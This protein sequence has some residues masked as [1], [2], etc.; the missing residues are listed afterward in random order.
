[1]VFDVVPESYMGFK[2]VNG[3]END[4]RFLDDKGVIVGLRYKK[5]NTKGF[6]NDAAFKNGF[7]IRTNQEVVKSKIKKAA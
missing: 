7:P 3:D 1:M 4:L 5:V 2:V 6:D